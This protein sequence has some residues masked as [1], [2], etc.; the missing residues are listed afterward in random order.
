MISPEDP[1][2]TPRWV[3]IPAGRYLMGG[4]PRANENPAH[5]VEVPGFL[6]AQTTVRRD[7]YQVFLEDT[8]HVPPSCWQEPQFS[9]PRMP[10][11]GVSWNDAEAYCRWLG[12][13]LK[14][15]V[16]LPTEAEWEW[17]AR[18]GRDVAYPWGDAPPESLTDYAK[19]WQDGPEVVDAYPSTHP[20][21]LL[22]LCENV[23][24][25][26]SDWYS[27]DYYDESP[28][29]HPQGPKSG[30]RRASR[31]GAW[32]HDV[33]VCRVTHRSSIPPHMTYTDYGF[34]V[35]CDL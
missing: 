34:R 13:R 22:G 24:E 20:W 33:K 32:R 8:E 1:I 6:L 4:G 19:R 18:A 30:R 9:H 7:Q 2:E 17:A 21:G 26:C 10:V 25:W 5:E 16:R 3:E 31:G 12:Q 35:A 15:P 14:R 27:A 28:V 29:S 11:V 23:H